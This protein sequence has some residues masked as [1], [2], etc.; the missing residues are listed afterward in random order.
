MVGNSRSNSPSLYLRGAIRKSN[1]RS[2]DDEGAMDTGQVLVEIQPQEELRFTFELRKQSFCSVQLVNISND[3]VAFKVKTTSPKR[4]CVQPNMGIILPR[5]TCNFTVTMQAPKETPRDMQLKDKFLVQSTVIPFGTT[6]ED[7]VPSFFFKEN[8]K[9]IQ[10]NKLR[11]ALI[12]HL[13]PPPP[14]NRTLRQEPAYD[15]PDLAEIS[16]ATN[17]ILKHEPAEEVP[18]LMETSISNSG[19]LKQEL[20]HEREMSKE[21]CNFSDQTLGG[22]VDVAQ[23]LVAEDID[24]LKLKLNNLEAKFNEAEKTITSMREE[25]NAAIQDRDKFQLEIAALRRKYVVNVQS[26]FPFSFIV[27]VALVTMA[28]GYLLHP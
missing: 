3:Y 5:S 18:I 4:Y 27:F 7:I 12:S 9:Y 19:A 10:E 6:D 22:V 1:L 11:V 14:E 2:R 26:G 8:G 13:H 28:F 21:T 20:D 25:N 23:S 16:I 24:E 17:G 15:I